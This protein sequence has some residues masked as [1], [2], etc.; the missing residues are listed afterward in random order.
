MA[1][2]EVTYYNSEMELV[3]LLCENNNITGV[4]QIMKDI[5]YSEEDI[6]K[7]EKKY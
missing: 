4:I 1:D 2:W 5:G 3:T 7:I 6:E